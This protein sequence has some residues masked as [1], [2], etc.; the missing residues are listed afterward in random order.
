MNLNI[1]SLLGKGHLPFSETEIAKSAPNNS[2]PF[3]TTFEALSIAFK[4]P[5]HRLL[6][7]NLKGFVRE[8]NQSDCTAHYFL[9]G[10]SFLTHPTPKDLD[11]LA[12]VDLEC[13]LESR[14]NTINKLHV[15]QTQYKTYKSIDVRIA[16]RNGDLALFIKSI[17]Y[18]SIL[19]SSS[20]IND[21]V[22]KGFLLIDVSEIHRSAN[23][24]K[25]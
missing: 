14:A 17:S 18:F 9:I 20:K 7:E 5:R 3:L 6:L 16:L 1:L 22:E 12:I 13:D 15:L 25:T 23:P 24:S 4:T 11:C 10:G 8:V 21:R 2:S 19:Y